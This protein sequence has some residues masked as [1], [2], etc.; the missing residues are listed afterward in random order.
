MR[1]WTVRRRIGAVA[2]GLLLSVGVAHAD[3]HAN[4]RPFRVVMVGDSIGTAAFPLVTGSGVYW[5]SDPGRS[6]YDPGA[7]GRPGTVDT[8]AVLADSL[9]NSTA[10]APTFMVVQEGA[11]GTLTGRYI[12]NAEWARFL[13]DVLRA[14]A[15]KCLVFVLPGYSKT[16]NGQANDTG[17]RVAYART[18]AATELFARNSH[19][20][21]HTINLLAAIDANPSFVQADGLHLTDAGNRWLAGQINAVV[22]R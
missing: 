22:N 5:D 7:A 13:N 12:D 14:T 1:F 15:G 4:P 6:P 19:R 16:I 21:I 3:A 11:T 10:Q 20:C 8:L 9:P 18:V 17:W 2:A